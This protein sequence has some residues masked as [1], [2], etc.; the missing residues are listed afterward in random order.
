MRCILLGPPGAGKGTLSESL[1]KEYNICHISTGD[2][3][4]EHIAAKTDIGKLASSYIEK[5]QLVPDQVVIDMAKDRILRPD[6]SQGFLFDGFPRTVA[7]GEA[8]NVMLREMGSAL[9]AVILLEADDDMLVGRLSKR[10]V[11]GKCGAV[12]HLVNKPPVKEGICDL[13]GEQLIQRADDTEAVIKDRL[14]VYHE[15]TA[16]LVDFY[17]NLSLLI[18]IDGSNKASEVAADVLKAL[19]SRH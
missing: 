2:M 9:D 4:R 5:G 10:R 13:D 18:R 7:Q 16:P 17:D 19:T 1:Q 3:F 11:C 15:Q 12:Y 8:L 6:C 14:R